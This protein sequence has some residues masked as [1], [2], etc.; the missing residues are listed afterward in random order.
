MVIHWVVFLACSGVGHKVKGHATDDVV[1][2]GRFRGE[3]NIGNDAVDIAAEFGRLRQQDRVIEARRNLL[4]VKGEWYSRMLVLTGCT[5]RV[6]VQPAMSALP[7]LRM[8]GERSLHR[9]TSFIA[10]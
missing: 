2:D 5:R 7:P 8:E 10:E 3:D 9:W 4:R 6:A 1:V